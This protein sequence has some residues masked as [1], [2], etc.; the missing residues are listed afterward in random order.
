MRPACAYLLLTWLLLSTPLSLSAQASACSDSVSR[1]MQFL[2][3]NWEGCSYSIAGSD[4][5]LDA[6][7]SIQSQ[8][9]YGGCVLEE[10]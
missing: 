2:Q 9:L 6:Q 5:T 8:P 1:S 3:G 7:M 10:R 4:T